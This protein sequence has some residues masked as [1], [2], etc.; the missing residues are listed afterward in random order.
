MRCGFLLVEGC[1]VTCLLF[2]SEDYSC[3]ICWL[4]NPYLIL[5]KW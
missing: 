1:M 4:F 2:N 5:F 3:V